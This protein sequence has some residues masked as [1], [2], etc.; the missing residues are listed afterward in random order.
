MPEIAEREEEVYVR[1]LF[2][3]LY[4]AH[5][6][7]IPESKQEGVRSPDYELLDAGE[8]VAVLEVKRLIRTPRT[9]E[10]R[11]QVKGCKEDIQEATRIDNGPQRVGALIHNASKQFAKFSGPKI[12]VFVN[13]ESLL[14]CLDLHEAF[15]G[16]L[17][18][19]NDSL[20]YYNNRVSAKIANGQIREEKWKIDLYVWIDRCRQCDP[21]FRVVTAVGLW[22]ARR[23][24]RCPDIGES[25]N[26][27]LGSG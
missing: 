27:A 9:P 2:H 22:L 26:R 12:V 15:N 17:S 13:D 19:G 25:P 8:R 5:L 18:Y 16:F 11:W 20:G 14:D 21:M 4:G 7:K 3:R 24:F 10:N 23:F 6:Q 1:E